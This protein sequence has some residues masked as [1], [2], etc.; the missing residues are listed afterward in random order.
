MDEYLA[1]SNDGQKWGV[2]QEEPNP[3]SP[4]PIDIPSYDPAV[5]WHLNSHVH[6]FRTLP[7]DPGDIDLNSSPNNLLEDHEGLLNFVQDFFDRLKLDLGNQGGQDLQADSLIGKYV[8][9]PD[10][11]RQI[12]HR[13]QQDQSMEPHTD[14]SINGW[15]SRPLDSRQR[16]YLKDYLRSV[17]AADEQLNGGAGRQRILDAFGRVGITL[18]NPAPSSDDPPDA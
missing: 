1:N 16:R 5:A 2:P 15:F 10:G 7:N 6:C 8:L 9:P 4:S 13:C 11:I 14:G 18:N 12:R 3:T 17:L